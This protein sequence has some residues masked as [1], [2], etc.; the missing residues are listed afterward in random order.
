M[1]S[2]TKNYGF[3]FLS[4]VISLDA[5]LVLVISLPFL[6]QKI[7]SELDSQHFLFATLYCHTVSKVID[8]K[9][10]SEQVTVFP[11]SSLASHRS[12]ANVPNAEH[13]PTLVCLSGL[14]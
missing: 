5:I 14:S 10:N 1:D 4:S 8:R 6:E 2:V 13:D 9:G 12:W 3:H 11:K 7:G